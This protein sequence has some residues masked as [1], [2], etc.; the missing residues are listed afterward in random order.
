MCLEISDSRGCLPFLGSF[1]LAFMA[2]LRVHF[3]QGTLSVPPLWPHPSDPR[4]PVSWHL[5][6]LTAHGLHFI[7]FLF[8]AKQS[9]EQLFL[10]SQ[11]FRGGGD[12]W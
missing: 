12:D 3:R 4:G 9:C 5:C 11:H 10:Y 6:H 1:C 2:Q 7:E 8:S